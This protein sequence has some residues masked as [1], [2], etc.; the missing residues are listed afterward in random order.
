MKQIT[1]AI[2]TLCAAL[3]APSAYADM[4]ADHSGEIMVRARAVQI[5][6]NNSTNTAPLAGVNAANKTIP[7]V[8]FSYFFTS[9]IAT[10]LILTYPQNI[11]IN[12]SVGSVKALPPT[13]TVQYH[14]LPDSQSFRPYVGAGIN[15]T[16]FSSYS[17]AGGALNG[18]SSSWGGALQAGFDVPLTSTMTFNVDVKKTYMKTDISTAAGAP[19]GT[20][21]LDPVLIGVG[22]GWK[23]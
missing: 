17:L 15:Y 6:F 20:L 18:S 19:V 7:E 12:P 1:S 5:D 9:H 10:E 22:L 14:F 4:Q 2:A 21:T 23:F 11:T 13:L 3:L 16:R 8:D